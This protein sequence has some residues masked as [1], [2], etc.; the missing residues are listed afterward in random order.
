MDPDSFP[1]LR[2]RPLWHTINGRPLFGL[3]VGSLCF[4]QTGPLSRLCPA[5]V[6]DMDEKD[7][8]L[9]LALL[10]RLSGSLTPCFSDDRVQHLQPGKWLPDHAVPGI[11]T[12]DTHGIPWSRMGSTLSSL[13][14]FTSRRAHGCRTWPSLSNVDE[15]IRSKSSY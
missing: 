14:P 10:R 4:L 15:P 8:K 2:I 5:G 7:R 11:E 1:P 13:V 9:L 12:R 6:P 3:E